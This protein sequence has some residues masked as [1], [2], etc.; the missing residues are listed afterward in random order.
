[1]PFALNEATELHQSHQVIGIHGHRQADREFSGCGCGAKFWVSR[2]NRANSHDEF[3]SLCR[4]ALAQPDRQ[5]IQQ[6]L[7]MAADN[8]WESIVAKLEGHIMDALTVRHGA[9]V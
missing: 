9:T 4:Q 5:R 3:I 6:G 2:A 7:D 1:M 8:T